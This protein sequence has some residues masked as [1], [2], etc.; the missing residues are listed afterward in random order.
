MLYIVLSQATSSPLYIYICIYIYIIYLFYSL[1]HPTRK[2][3]SRVNDCCDAEPPSGLNHN[4]EQKS[5]EGR[6]EA[7]PG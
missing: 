6:G 7:E 2:G 5:D 4:R 3:E 1:P